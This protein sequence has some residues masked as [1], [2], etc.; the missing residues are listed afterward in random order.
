MAGDERGRRARPPGVVGPAARRNSEE[1]AMKH[2]PD[3]FLEIFVDGVLAALLL[4]GL[5]YFLLRAFRRDRDDGGPPD[6]QPP[7]G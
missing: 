4:A 2:E 3:G 1:G 5:I 6:E 7:Y